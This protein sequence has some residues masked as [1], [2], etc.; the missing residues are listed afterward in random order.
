MFLS[1]PIFILTL[2]I[3]ILVHEAGHFLVAK[4]FKIKVLEFGFGFPPK[5]WGKKIG[6]TIYSINWLPLGGFV[7]LH[8]EDEAGG[9]KFKVQSSKFIVLL[10]KRAFFVLPGS[11]LVV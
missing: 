6:E 3:L 11:Q 7:K 2:L 8:G 5:A 4:K 10:E 1:I 9:G